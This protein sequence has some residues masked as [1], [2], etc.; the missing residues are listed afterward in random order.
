LART[1][2]IRFNEVYRRIDDFKDILRAEIFRIEQVL[3]GA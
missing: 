1:V 3:D 2:D